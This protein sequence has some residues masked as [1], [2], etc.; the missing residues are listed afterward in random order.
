MRAYLRNVYSHLPNLS[1]LSAPLLALLLKLR[2][3][4][5]TVRARRLCDRRS[6]CM[7]VF[8]FVIVLKKL[9][10]Q[11]TQQREVAEGYASV[12]VRLRAWPRPATLSGVWSLECGPPLS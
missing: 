3:S 2:K 11:G 7:T 12:R 4:I 1:S 9:C 8:V 6:A 10:E 5:T